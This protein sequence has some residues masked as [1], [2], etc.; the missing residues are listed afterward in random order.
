MASS[1]SASARSVGA[2]GV[3]TAT[4]TKNGTQ[5]GALETRR[6]TKV[7][8]APDPFSR[9]HAVFFMY[10]QG[11]VFKVQAEGAADRDRWIAAVAGVQE[12]ADFERTRAAKENEG[13]DFGRVEQLR[14]RSRSTTEGLLGGGLGLA[15]RQSMYDPDDDDGDDGA[16]IA[17][18]AAKGGSAAAPA[19]AATA[20]GP[21]DAY[22]LA[23]AAEQAPASPTRTS[24]T[25]LPRPAAPAVSSGLRFGTPP[26]PADAFATPPGTPRK[27]STASATSATSGSTS[28]AS[29]S[30]VGAPP[31]RAGSA[32]G[33]ESP[34]TAQ[35]SAAKMKSP[36]NR[37]GLGRSMPVRRSN[38]PAGAEALAFRGSPT[39]GAMSPGRRASPAGM[40]RSGSG[41]VLWQPQLRKHHSSSAAFSGRGDVVT[42]LGPRFAPVLERMNV[43]VEALLVALAEAQRGDAHHDTFVIKQLELM[44]SD[45]VRK[46]QENRL[47]SEYF[48]QLSESLGKLLAHGTEEKH[49]TTLL[50]ALSRPARI[51]ECLEVHLD[52]DNVD[53]V[54]LRDP[55]GTGAE[56][57]DS[58]QTLPRYIRNKLEEHFGSTEQ[59]KR[60]ASSTSLLDGDGSGNSSNSGPVDLN[61]SA[62]SVQ[63]SAQLKDAQARM[64]QFLRDL[65]AGD[66]LKRGDFD[67]KKL[68]SS[69]NFGSV[70]LSQHAASREVVAVKVLPKKAIKHQNLVTQV[71]E[72]RNIMKFASNP[73]LVEFYGSFTTKAHLFMV[74]EFIHG[75][76]VAALLKNVGSL[77]EVVARQYMAETVLAVEYIHEYGITHRDLKPDNLVITASG[78][79]KVTDFGLSQTGLMTKTVLIAERT[80][81]F[82]DEPKDTGG[83][84]TGAAAAA[85]A[86]TAAGGT[87]AVVAG[88][89]VDLESAKKPVGT[90]GYMAPEVILGLQ[91][92]ESVDWWAMGIILFE[93]LGGYLPFD[94]AT[95]EEVF[96]NT[97]SQRVVFPQGED[98]FSPTAETFIKEL[99]VKNAEA[100]VGSLRH[101]LPRDMAVGRLAATLPA[102]GGLFCE[103]ES[104]SVGVKFNAFFAARPSEDIPDE[105]D[106]DKLVNSKAAFVP[107]LDGEM[108]TSYFDDRADRYSE[109]LSEARQSS[110]MSTASTSSNS[111]F[112][113]SDSTRLRTF[114]T[115]KQVR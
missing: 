43:E 71:F 30:T 52:E 65:K 11:R 107:Q 44:A 14:S 88:A 23:T 15:R 115:S 54:D 84:D 9:R 114:S 35:R 75:G 76:D 95:P 57:A 103:T 22:R 61:V 19:T 55:D 77:D 85:A 31:G 66:N 93:M 56:G 12:P 36:L 37:G 8:K 48:K 90:P 38:I 72:E 73:F 97:V 89:G 13:I 64:P 83:A 69:G 106:W 113:H 60:V 58:H 50:L 67:F 59:A 42:V 70:Y 91:C 63:M 81:R 41:S 111:V 47:S 24:Q 39:Q 27:G 45:L 34:T 82:W 5:K 102:N 98:R 6:I 86:N 16:Y 80:G 92:G 4:V 33:S 17:P 21:Q 7:C 108:D 109:T 46:P 29:A 3:T 101:I 32:D 94:G 79:I 20:G 26:P 51:A 2:G 18:A 53:V 104:V 78:H 87:D 100:R 99:L 49:I 112:E 96:E 105:I 28:D 62:S 40:L 10:T 110:S 25:P 74:M 1:R 68:I